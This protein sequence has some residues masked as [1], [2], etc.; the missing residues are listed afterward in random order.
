MS[1]LSRALDR[2]LAAADVWLRPPP[3]V[4]PPPANES[5]VIN[6]PVDGVVDRRWQSSTFH[7]ER[8]AATECL[9]GAAKS[10]NWYH[11]NDCIAK[12]A[13]EVRR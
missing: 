3:Y 4:A 12:R 6:Q 5:P 11:C 8:L 7:V 13:A 10:V 2:V 1:F 9:C